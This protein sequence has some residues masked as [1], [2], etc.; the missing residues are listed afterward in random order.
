MITGGDKDPVQPRVT[1]D[2]YVIPETVQGYAAPRQ[3]PRLK[4]TIIAV[5]VIAV[6]TFML[7]I[8]ATLQFMGPR[9][10]VVATAPAPEQA[11]PAVVE[12]EAVVA[13]STQETVTRQE[14]VDLLTTA[15]SEAQAETQVP[16]LQ[17]A[18]L[19]GLRCCA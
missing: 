12:L 19:Q 11:K 16:A 1:F 2:S 13:A 7:G 14:P 3:S 17:A 10:V 8:L 15:V 9:Q 5:S 4:G 18:V 6:L